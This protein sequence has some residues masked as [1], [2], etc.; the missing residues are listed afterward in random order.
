[1]RESRRKISEEERA[2]MKI[3]RDF[4][5]RGILFPEG[6]YFQRDFISIMVESEKDYQP[7][8]S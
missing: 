4:I 2:G 3:Q 8:W 6:F 7:L 1:M 5:S